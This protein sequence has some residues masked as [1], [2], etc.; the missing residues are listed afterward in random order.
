MSEARYDIYFR[1]DLL[2]GFYADFV[3]A[4]MAQLFKTDPARLAAF[5]SGTPQPI[6]LKVD[7]PTAAK[8]KAALEKIG[9]K[10]IIV[11]M[12]KAPPAVTTPGQQ[13][14]N[15]Q[16]GQA[17]KAASTPAGESD[18]TIL[19]AGSDIG[20]HRDVRPVAVETGGLSLA[21]AGVTLV[22]HP[23]RPTPV[24]VDISGLS[25]DEPGVNL[26]ENPSRPA[27]FQVDISGLSLDEPGVTLVENDKAAPPP[28]PDIS[29]LTLV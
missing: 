5:F 26:V 24:P 6:K 23:E 2:D 9:A 17:G 15:G 7:K 21:Q 14:E 11:P 8:Y 19:P 16:P 22:E 29:H 20:E 25:L 12:G 3:K 18:W 1:G 27:P 4:D 13:P 28:P 10:P